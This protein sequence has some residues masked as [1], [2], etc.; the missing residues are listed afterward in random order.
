MTMQ[1]AK[2]ECADQP[3]SGCALIFANYARNRF[4]HDVT[5]FYM[6]F[7]RQIR[8]IFDGL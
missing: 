8:S 5:R 7:M 4:S 6:C 2:N 3:A 1:A